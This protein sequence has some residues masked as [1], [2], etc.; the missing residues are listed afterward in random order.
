MRPY[1]QNNALG[2]KVMDHY[3]GCEFVDMAETLARGKTRR[4]IRDAAACCR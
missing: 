3:G 2:P 4:E 1:M